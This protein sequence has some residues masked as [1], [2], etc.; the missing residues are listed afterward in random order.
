LDDLEP[1]LRKWFGEER[2][3]LGT[4]VKRLELDRGIKVSKSRLAEWWAARVDEDSEAE[5]LANIA[6]GSRL[7]AEVGRLAEDAPVGVEPMVKLLQGLITTI[8]VRGSL[9]D[10][11]KHVPRLA[12]V[13]F[14]GIKRNQAAVLLDQNDR[15]IK[16][17]EQKAAQADAAKAV[18]GDANLTEEQ[19]QAKFREIFGMA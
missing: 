7:A 8:S 19:K 12:K 18:A 2:A 15:R 13:V 16:L 1:E 10:Q 6:S 5:L 14:D 11:V 4:V 3:T 17:L 9:P